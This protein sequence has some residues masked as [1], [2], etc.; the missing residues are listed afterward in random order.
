MYVVSRNVGEQGNILR[1]LRQDAL[2]HVIT[3]WNRKTWL[4][5]RGLAAMATAA[6]RYEGFR[7][8]RVWRDALCLALRLRRNQLIDITLKRSLASREHDTPS[9]RVA[10]DTPWSTQMSPLVSEED[11]A[12]SDQ[13]ALKAST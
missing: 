6:L 12:Q 7:H 8:R 3:A 1:Y 5:C 13:A 11:N 2:I 9:R 4:Y 10:L